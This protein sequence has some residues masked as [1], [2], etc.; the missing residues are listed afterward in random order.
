M[1]MRVFN[2][3]FQNNAG[4][5][6]LRCFVPISQKYSSLYYYWY[7]IFVATRNYNLNTSNKI[8][9]TIVKLTTYTDTY[10]DSNSPEVVCK[11]LIILR[12]DGC[13]RKLCRVS[14]RTRIEVLLLTKM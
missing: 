7:E 4:S 13:M 3:F 10:V 5:K 1:K 9:Q 6:D 8:K 12:R 14:C 11:Y 2:R